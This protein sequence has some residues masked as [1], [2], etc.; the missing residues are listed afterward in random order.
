MQPRTCVIKRLNQSPVVLDLLLSQQNGILLCSRVFLRKIIFALLFTTYFQN[1]GVTLSRAR[2]FLENLRPSQCNCD[3][4]FGPRKNLSATF[5]CRS[6]F[7]CF[8]KS[9]IDRNRFTYVDKSLNAG[10]TKPTV[11]GSWMQS[12]SPVSV[13]KKRRYGTIWCAFLHL[14][15][16]Q[17]KGSKCETC[18]SI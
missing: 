7:S 14:L 13:K 4:N 3:C 2:G 11:N 6:N 8:K 12:Q 18:T 1:G 17:V 16:A 9:R 15:A 5:W 10:A